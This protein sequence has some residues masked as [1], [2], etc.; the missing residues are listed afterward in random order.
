MG[1]KEEKLIYSILKSINIYGMPFS[2]RYK[3]KSTYV[4]GIGIFLSLISIVIIFSLFLYYFLQLINHT[5]FTILNNN[6]KRKGHSIDLSNIP[7]MFGLIDI[8]SKLLQINQEF[9][10]VSIW[11]K[12]LIPINNSYGNVTFTRLELENCNESIYQN[13]YPDMKKYDLSKYLCIKSNQKIEINGRYGDSINGFNSINIYLSICISEDCLNKT[14]NLKDLENIIYGSYFSIHYLSQSI[15]HYNYKEPLI[16]NFRSENFEV[17]PFAHKKF[18]YF[19]SSMT[20]ISNNGILFDNNKN[21]TSFMFDHLHLDFVGRNNS[22]SIMFYDNNEYSNII[23]IIFSCADY[24]II[25]C[26]TYLKL[27]DIFINIGGLVDFIFIVFNSITIYFSRK[28]LI[29]DISNNL[30]CNKCIDACTKY[31]N[32]SFY[33]ISKFIRKE[34]FKKNYTVNNTN[35]II[36]SDIKKITSHLNSFNFNL[37][38]NLKYLHKN[39]QLSNEENLQFKNNNNKNNSSRNYLNNTN[40]EKFLTSNYNLFHPQKLNISLF[41]YMIPYFCLKKYK[42]Y[43]LLC[44]YTNIMYSY[45]SLEEILPSIERIGRLYRETVNNELIHSTKMNNV[46]S[47]KTKENEK[48]QSIIL[49]KKF[50][51]E[52]TTI[53]K[54]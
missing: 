46:F 3:N 53:S 24:P 31:H 10:S 44:A 1:Q 40:L 21:Y 12:N 51:N 33:N 37:N 14:N 19:Y 34:N 29:V 22:D 43:D 54:I 39:Q 5:S 27:T 49:T 16:N 30:V 15:D 52:I 17:T 13:E 20:Y 26:R 36:N 32:N 38:D 4:S 48:S 18:L 35:D 2:I 25:Y 8:N 28:N 23:D 45:L 41:D 7:I 6:D 47:Y 11:T 50:D 9:L 42:K